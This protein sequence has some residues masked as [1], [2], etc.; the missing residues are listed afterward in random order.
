MLLHVGI[1]LPD[2]VYGLR[3]RLADADVLTE[4]PW[5][6][7]P[8]SHS[9]AGEVPPPATPG[10]SRRGVLAATGIGDRRSWSPPR[11]GQTVTP[12]EPIG[13]LA[14]RRWRQGPQQVP[15]NRTA[16]Q[17]AIA[18]DR[19]RRGLGAAGGRTA[20]VRDHPRRPGPRHAHRGPAADQLR[21]GLERRARPGAA[22]V[23]S[24]W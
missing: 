12:L 17:A 5:D 16:E 8:V 20:T 21:R 15:V 24:S 19:D 3:A 22:S 18:A 13:L 14:V 10:I 11:S 2:I 4:I 23:C 1:K 9:N 7:N 6:E